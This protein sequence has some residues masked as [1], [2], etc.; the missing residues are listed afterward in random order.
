M[1]KANNFLKTSF[2]DFWPKLKFRFRNNFF[3]KFP[4]EIS[5]KEENRK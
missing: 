3:V 1:K 5:K 4:F 2:S